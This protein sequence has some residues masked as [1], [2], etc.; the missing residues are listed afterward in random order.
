MSVCLKKI[1]QTSFSIRIQ[2]FTFSERCSDQSLTPGVGGWIPSNDV[3]RPLHLRRPPD[4]PKLLRM[5]TIILAAFSYFAWRICN[6]IFLPTIF[7][8][9][10]WPS[11]PNQSST[12]QIVSQLYVTSSCAIVSSLLHLQYICICLMRLVCTAV[13]APS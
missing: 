3:W 4:D 8:C 2:R 1:A 13:Y 10:L 12:S 9:L 11:E 5:A 7:Y 6:W